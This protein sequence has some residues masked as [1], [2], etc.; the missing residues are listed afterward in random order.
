LYDADPDEDE[1]IGMEYE[2]PIGPVP[3]GYNDEPE[4]G[5]FGI[6][7]AMNPGWGWSGLQDLSSIPKS[8]DNADED[9][10]DSNQAFDGDD[11]DGGADLRTLEAFGDDLSSFHDVG[12]DSAHHTSPIMH[13]TEHDEMP[14]LEM[15]GEHSMDTEEVMDVIGAEV[16]EDVDAPVAE[17][18]V[19][20]DTGLEHMKRE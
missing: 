11:E 3:P 14:E 8:Y 16:E 10:N 13:S 15:L 1:G 9:D 6:H 19:D 12:I 4:T 20:E 2:A 5:S 17:V 18:R 7:S